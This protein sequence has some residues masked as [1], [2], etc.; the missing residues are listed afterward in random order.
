MA[1]KIDAKNREFETA[2]R[3][4]HLKR[5]L[6]KDSVNSFSPQQGIEVPEGPAKSGP[7]GSE[8]EL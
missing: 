7:V 4:V 2:S 6:L 1:E 3:R 5:R 8:E